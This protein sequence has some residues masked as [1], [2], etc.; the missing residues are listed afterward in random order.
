LNDAERA[1]IMLIENLQRQG[2]HPL[3]PSGIASGATFRPAKETLR[4]LAVGALM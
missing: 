3:E 2:L 1:E 4:L